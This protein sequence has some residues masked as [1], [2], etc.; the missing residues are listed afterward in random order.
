MLSDREKTDGGHSASGQSPLPGMQ[1]WP[2]KQI[3]FGQS[4]Q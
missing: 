2:I 1:I 4:L 3:L